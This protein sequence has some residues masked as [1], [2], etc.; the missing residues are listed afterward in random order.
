[1]SVLSSAKEFG[2]FCDMLERI[3][4]SEE[5]RL[6]EIRIQLIAVCPVPFWVV[7]PWQIIFRVDGWEKRFREDVV[8]HIDD[9]L[10]DLEEDEKEE[11]GEED[12]GVSNDAETEPI[13]V[14]TKSEIW[15]IPLC[16][17]E[18]YLSF[19]FFVRSRICEGLCSSLCVRMVYFRCMHV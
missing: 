16:Q 6:D 2:W 13:T 7:S 12:K 5:R 15:M 3:L 9:C 11:E 18:A 19:F 1:M 4:G 17:L 14:K 10:E 8:G